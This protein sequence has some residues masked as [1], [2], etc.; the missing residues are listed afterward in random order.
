MHAHPHPHQHHDHAAKDMRLLYALSL[1]ALFTLV[2]AAGGLWSGSLALLADAGHMLTDTVALGLAFG[3]ARLAR[4]PADPLRSYGYHRVQI[5]AAFINGIGFLLMVA[6][7]LV[8]AAQ[9]LLDPPQVMGE[10]MLW[11]AVLGLLVNLAAFKLLHG[12]HQ[13]DLNVRSALL[14]V[15]G[16]LL[17]SAAAIVAGVV[18]LWTGWMPID[19]LL[20]VLVA[21]L[22][23]RSAIS[24][25]RQSGHILLEGAPVDQDAAL[26]HDTL[27]AEIPAVADVHH[28][29]LWSLTPDR[30]LLTLHASVQ[31]DADWP[32]TLERIKSVLSERF[33]LA[34]STVQLEAG[35]CADHD[36]PV[37]P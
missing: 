34:H 7:I 5:L 12:G 23:L 21:L 33:G 14:H 10:L 32:A 6:W 24:V 17:G 29:H 20:S 9:R 28:V 31:P 26:I 4:R 8:E 2:E 3:A 18:I 35:A 13:H 22:I 11:V 15:L 36:R 27:M 19:P 30:P 25:V 37:R 16:D 1:T